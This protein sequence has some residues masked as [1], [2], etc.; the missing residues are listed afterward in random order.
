MGHTD[1]NECTSRA[2]C[3]VTSNGVPLCEC[4]SDCY[5]YG[6]C[7]SD[8]SHVKNCVGEWFYI[9][10]C[11]YGVLLF[12]HYLLAVEEC[13]TGDIRLVGGGTNS[14][15]RLEVCGN[16][17]WG[18]VCNRFRYWGTENARVVCRQLGFSEHGKIIHTVAGHA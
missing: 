15:G 12:Y 5:E 1:C 11:I 18:K 2:D 10:L 9:L 7:C 17:I 8:V 16:G 14:T 13:E 3:G 6:D 4:Y